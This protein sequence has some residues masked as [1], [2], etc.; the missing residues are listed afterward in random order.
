MQLNHDHEAVSY[1]MYQEH[2]KGGSV[3]VH[4]KL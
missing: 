2:M 4:V 1:L 3:H